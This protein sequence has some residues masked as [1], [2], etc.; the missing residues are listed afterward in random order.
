MARDRSRSPVGASGSLKK[1][2]EEGP[3]VPII[4]ISGL[5]GDD[6]A[7][8]RSV[9]KEIGEACEKIGFMVIRNH[10]I[11]QEIIDAAWERTSDFF[12]QPLAEKMKM[13]TEDEEKY[14]YGYSAFGGEVLSAGK[15]LEKRDSAESNADAAPVGDLKEM[16]SIG[17]KDAAAGMMPRQWPE[18]PAGFADAYAAY[19]DAINELARVLLKAFAMALD[20]PEDWFDDKMDKHISALR[21]NNYPDQKGMKVPAGSIRC[22]AHTDYGTITILKSG[23]PGLQVS[24]DKENPMWHDVPFIKDAFVI[25]LGD[26][27]RR[28]TNDRWS[29]TLHRV[30]N[31]PAGDAAA[32]GRR[33]SLAFFHNLNKDAQ[34]EAIPSCVSEAHP[35]LYDPIVAGEFLM[36]KHLASNGK[37]DP[38]AHLTKRG[39]A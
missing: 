28:W 37:A 17:P 13:K 22:S 31:P 25:N 29:S 21:A 23:G 26:L 6:Q 35:A 30:V 5:F 14:P 39:G 12:A 18:D 36:L 16:W 1:S 32:W 4:D 33:M 19:Y 8:K 24:K 20:L 38:D 27:M 7:V 3:I 9:A 10:G 34:V 15:A 11:P 2:S